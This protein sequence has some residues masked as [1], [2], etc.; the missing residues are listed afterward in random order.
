MYAFFFL[1][2]YSAPLPFLPKQTCLH[3][4]NLS[5]LVLINLPPPC[6]FKSSLLVCGSVMLKCVSYLSPSPFDSLGLL[7]T[8][9]SGRL[10]NMFVSPSLY[11]NGLGLFVPLRRFYF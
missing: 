2:P 4:P 6:V 10:H 1:V 11:L 8:L 3:F 9:S 5:H 7:H